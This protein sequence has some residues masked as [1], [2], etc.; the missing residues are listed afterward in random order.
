MH[1]KRNFRVRIF[2]CWRKKEISRTHST[3]DVLSLEPL[4]TSSATWA[5][6]PP[7]ILDIVMG[8]LLF[9]DRIRLGAVCM[10]WHSA[11]RA[12]PFFFSA[13]Q[14][15]WLLLVNKLTVTTVTFFDLS[16]KKIYRISQPDPPICNRTWC[17]SSNGW[18]VTMDV[19]SG[20]LLLNPVTGSQIQ[21]PPLASLPNMARPCRMA[22]VSWNSS[23]SRRYTVM[24]A[25]LSAPYLA[26]T[27]EGDQCWTPLEGTRRIVD[28]V[29]HN[30]WFYTLDLD[31]M[32]VAWDLTG[33]SP[34]VISVIMPAWL[35]S[36][37]SYGYLV[38]S[39]SGLLQVWRA[40]DEMDFIIFELDLT[41]EE[42]I[43]IE[44]LGGRALFLDLFCSLCVSSRDLANLRANCIYF[45]TGYLENPRREWGTRRFSFENRSVES[46]IYNSQSHFWETWIFSLDDGTIEPIV[47]P[48]SHWKQPP[49]WI[50]PR[51][52]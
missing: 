41:T 43:R 19:A 15:P 44:G 52:A 34:L 4:P 27:H 28:L 47:H 16:E 21:L 20:L 29:V 51:W 50:A 14:P 1:R 5:N 11:A 40:R 49:I 45:T 8:H 33:P 22:R 6:L 13:P 39:E 18:L 2:D 26:Y 24:L 48:Q 46:I 30:E 42:W 12:S 17:G 32:V 10:S 31:G 25:L 23:T 7:D 36:K 37:V 35:P 38:D 9:P 3:T